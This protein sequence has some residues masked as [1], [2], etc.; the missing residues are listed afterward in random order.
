MRLVDPAWLQVP[1]TALSHCLLCWAEQRPYNKRLMDQ[2]KA[3]DRQL[4]NYCHEQKN[5]ES[6]KLI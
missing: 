3:R 6:R 1:I 4:T 5:L 2:D